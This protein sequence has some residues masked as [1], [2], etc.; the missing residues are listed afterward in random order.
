[1]VHLMTGQTI[2]T[3]TRYDPEQNLAAV[4]LHEIL[5]L[6]DRV[7]I[8]GPDGEVN[9]CIET[10]ERDETPIRLAEAGQEIG[11]RVPGP[12]DAGSQVDM[13]LEAPWP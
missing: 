3:V 10:L 2:G 9:C 5:R 1:M 8:R 4:R 12:V 7:C 6:G 13:E 11:I